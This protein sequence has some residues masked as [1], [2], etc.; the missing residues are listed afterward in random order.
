VKIK[1]KASKSFDSWK[2]GVYCGCGNPIEIIPS[3]G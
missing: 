1:G 3:V 2:S